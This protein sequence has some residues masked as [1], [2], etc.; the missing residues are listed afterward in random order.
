MKIQASLKVMPTMNN[1]VEV[2]NKVNEVIVMI[3][4]SNLKYIIGPSETAIEGSFKDVFNL[5]ELIHTKL[6]NDDIEQ[7]TMVIMTD[8]N[9]DATYIEEKLSNVN[10]YLNN[11]D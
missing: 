5:V 9:K 1:R 4:N 8:Y 10:N 7:I 2:Y 3:V 11:N 6:V